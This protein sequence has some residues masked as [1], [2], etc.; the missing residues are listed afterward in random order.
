MFYF[1]SAISRFKSEVVAVKLLEDTTVRISDRQTLLEL[2]IM[3]EIDHE[4]LNPFVGICPEPQNACLLMKYA[5][6]GSLHDILQDGN[7]FL[8]L[9]FKVSLA[10]DIARGMAFIHNTVLGEN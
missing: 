2:K 6:R 8:P 10:S 9:D 3:K 4:N 5:P 1:Y 7:T